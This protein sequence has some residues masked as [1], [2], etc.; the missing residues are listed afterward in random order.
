MGQARRT[1]RSIYIPSRGRFKGRSFPSKHAY[2]NA[3]AKAR[4]FRSDYARRTVY[5]RISSTRGLN[6]LSPKS[7]QKRSDA[8]NVV[9]IMRRSDM[10]LAQAVREHNRNYPDSRISV[11]AMKKYAKPA[12]VKRGG[13]IKAKSYDRLLRVMRV[14]S[15]LGAELREVKDSRTASQVAKYEN[16]VK[17]YLYTGDESQLRQFQG[18]YFRSNRLQY[19]FITDTDI[20][21]KLAEFGEL[22]FESIYTQLDGE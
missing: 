16:A 3:L 13:R 1:R 5:K 12:L 15:P 9:G 17:T 6:A 21:D 4:G 2:R 22:E 19:R 10:N 20:L 18:K 14:P 11:S 8:L 7:R